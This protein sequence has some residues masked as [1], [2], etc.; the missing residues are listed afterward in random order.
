MCCALVAK[1]RVLDVDLAD[2]EIG[3]SSYILGCW[4]LLERNQGPDLRGGECM[5]AR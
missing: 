3:G 4:G 2:L 1:T 5:S